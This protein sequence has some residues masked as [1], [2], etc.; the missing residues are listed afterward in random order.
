MHGIMDKGKVIGMKLAG[1]SNRA[2]NREHGYDRDK[3]AQVW[4]EYNL[5][6]AQMEEPKPTLKQSKTRCVQ[7]PS[8]THPNEQSVSIPSW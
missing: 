1:M 5:A 7:I 3:V 4:D 2:I 8:M 6:L